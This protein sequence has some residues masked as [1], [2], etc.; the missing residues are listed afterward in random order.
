MT[1]DDATTTWHQI[2][3]KRDQGTTRHTCHILE[4]IH[5]A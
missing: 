5:V 2:L 4:G 3:Y 1:R